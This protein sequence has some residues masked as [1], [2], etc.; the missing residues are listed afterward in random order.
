MKIIDQILKFRYVIAIFVFIFSVC[1]S[2]HGSSINNWSNFGVREFT[3]GKQEM[4]PSISSDNG[5]FNL[6]SYVWQWGTSSESSDSVILGTP[7]MI[8]TDEWL[9]QTPFYLSQVSQDFPLINDRYGMSGQNMIVAYNAPVKHISVIGKPFNWGFLF[10][11]SEKG[12]SWYWSFK[13]IVMLLLAYEFSLILTQKNKYLSA[14]G[15]FWITF[16][17]SIQWWFMQHLGDIVFYTL[18]IVVSMYHYFCSTKITQKLLL[19]AILTS[20]LIGFVL[21]IYPAFQVP[22]AYFILFAFI[23]FLWDY[24]KQKR[25]RKHD[26]V[27]ISMSLLLSFGIIGYSLYESHEAI[28]ATLNTIYPGHRISIGGDLPLNRLS[29]IVLSPFLAFS[30]PHYLNQVELSN[31]LNILPF[32]YL[33]LPFNWKRL[34]FEKNKLALLILAYALL[35]FFYTFIS[36]PEFISRVTLFSFVTSSRAWQALSVISVFM[37]IWYIDILW[38]Q[39]LKYNKFY[40]I[41]I[42]IIVSFLSFISMSNADMVVYVGKKMILLSLLAIL[43]VL[44]SVIYKFKKSF[45]LLMSLLIF[46]SGMTIN[47]LVKGLD[48]IYSKR[49]SQMIQ[50]IQAR[51]AQAVWVSDGNL[52][53]Y[54]QMLGVKTLNSVRFYPDFKMMSKISSLKED[55]IFWNRY[56]HIKVTSNPVETVEM[57]NPAPDVL[58]LKLPPSHLAELGIKYVLT[59]ENNYYNYVDYFSLIYGPDQDGNIILELGKGE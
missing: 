11:G 51:D 59:Q 12:L 8:R 47:P 17:P 9:V 40:M 29:D 16:T 56:S 10:L 57:S 3:D 54:P 36:I 1:F 23:V 26:V 42:L 43:L 34:N 44:I 25:F 7:K 18:A 48:T 24:I 52:Y 14:L 4:V 58:E 49:L 39:S 50:S 31:S 22:F 35:L 21:V 30:V 2:F 20:S 13:L 55:E 53:N 38:K 32:I 27:L 33:T 41:M 19:A 45:V 28:S 37:S 15:A 5:Q 46:L 6:L